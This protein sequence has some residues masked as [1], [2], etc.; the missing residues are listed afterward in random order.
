MAILFQL[1]RGNASVF[2]NWSM[3]FNFRAMKVLCL[4]QIFG[5]RVCKAMHGY[6]PKLSSQSA[7]SVVK[8]LAPH[9]RLEIHLVYSFA[10]SKYFENFNRP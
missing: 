6:D 2:Q 4:R 7:F 5:A 3:G 10:L 8:Q 9:S 1:K